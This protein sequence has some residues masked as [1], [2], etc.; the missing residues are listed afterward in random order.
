M[1][2]TILLFILSPDE[3]FCDYSILSTERQSQREAIKLRRED[4]DYR[5]MGK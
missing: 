4:D 3:P 2:I 1:L 5:A